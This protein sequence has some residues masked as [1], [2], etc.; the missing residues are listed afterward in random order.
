MLERLIGENIHLE[1]QPA[2]EL[3]SVKADPAQIDQILTNLCVNARDAIAGQGRITIGTGNSTFDEAYCATREGLA[4][5]EYV[6]LKVRDDGCGMDQET[7]TH[8]FE[9]FFTTKGVGAGTGL[10]LAS[11]YGAVKQN[12]GFVEVCSAP[13]KGATFTVYL[14]RHVG[15][16]APV[17][18]EAVL[19]PT[20]SHETI[21]L[22]EDEPAILKVVTLRLEQQGYTVLA[23]ST[24]GEAVRLFHAQAGVIDLLLTDVLMPE[25]N[26]REL[27]KN[28]RLHQR[29]LKCLFMS[30]YSTDVL[31]D[32]GVLDDAASFLTKPF[33]AQDLLTQVREALASG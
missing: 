8:I 31:D 30:G 23:A 21:L 4:P 15:A 33:S 27:A 6:H 14:P 11:V 7:Q 25:M 20:V 18:A 24:P 12:H 22:V 1:W 26:G 3:W 13:G 10:G 29:S 28:L 2:P 9:P 19:V 16:A 32:R 17:L 5:G